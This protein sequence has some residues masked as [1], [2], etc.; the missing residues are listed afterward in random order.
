MTDDET[1]TTNIYWNAVDT[2]TI[3]EEEK[4]V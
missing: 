3:I 2:I 4:D 1:A